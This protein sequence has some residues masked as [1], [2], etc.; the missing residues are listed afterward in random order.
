MNERSTSALHPSG[1]AGFVAVATAAAIVSVPIAWATDLLR[2]LPV[3]MAV[4]MLIALAVGLPILIVLRDRRG[5]SWRSVVKGGFVTGAV[6]PALLSLL[7]LAQIIGGTTTIGDKAEAWAGF[8]AFVGVPGLAGILGAFITW[9][10]IGWLSADRA[11][12]FGRRW[13]IGLLAALVVGAIFGGAAVPGL[14]VDRSCHNPMRDGRSSID[15]VAGFE[16]RVPINDWPALRREL[17]RFTQSRNW[18]FRDSTPPDRDMEWFDASVCTEAGT[19]IGT[20]YTAAG[21]DSVLFSVYQPQGGDSWKQP[22]RALQ[23][24]LEKRWP[25]KV[26]YQSGPYAQPAPPWPVAASASDPGAHPRDG[27]VAAGAEPVDPAEAAARTAIS[28][29]KAPSSATR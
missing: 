4:T 20:I 21:G 7:L 9:G 5:V 14:Y 11:S 3:V 29:R 18:S 25:G 15:P 1:C 10:L 19:Q 27:R 16:L 26:A 23:R 24:Q 17:R 13:R 28:L 2:A 8:V 22:A 6:V 12:A